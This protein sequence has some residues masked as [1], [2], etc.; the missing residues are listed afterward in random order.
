MR[1]RHGAR[2]LCTLI[3][4]LTLCAPWHRFAGA[5]DISFREW[6]S[7]CQRAPSNRVLNGRFPRRAEMPLPNLEALH[8]LL[9]RVLVNYR[10][11]AMANTDKWVGPAPKAAEFFD[12]KRSY[13]TRPTIPFQPFAQKVVAEA[14]AEFIF[15]GDFHGDVRSFVGMLQ[16][17]NAN[18]RMDGFRLKNRRCYLVF[19]GDYTD[20]GAYGVEVLYTL[21]RLAVEN[22]GRVLMARGNHEDFLLTA[23]YGFLHE[24]RTKYG[25]ATNPLRICRMFDFL[26]VVIYLGVGKHYLQCNHG[27]MEPGYD[28][29][30]LLNAKG[31]ER[32]ELLGEITRQKFQQANPQWVAPL[33]A[34]T[35]ELLARRMQDFRPQNPTTPNSIGFMWSDYALYK[36]ATPLGYNTNRMAF[37]FGESP[38]AYLLRVASR[39]AAQLHAVFR[40]HQHSSAPNPM[41]NRLIASRGAFRHWQSTDTVRQA[42]AQADLLKSLVDTRPVRPVT[43]GSVWTWNVSPDSVYGRGNRYTF[44]TIGILKTAAQFSQWKVEVVN[45]PINVR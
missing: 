25:P 19:L 7:R 28:P 44:D 5:E 35:R 21:F 24:L 16:W 6:A 37:V 8:Q 39:G 9:D 26:P 33:D 17:L 42:N 36:D 14:G 15:H 10:S 3:V 30:N 31:A 20:R 32:Y 12:T 2:V 38:T 45:I 13:F 41:M 29:H 18:G 40:A 23:N 22:P 34:R 11:G 27:G 4:P 43:Q 1:N